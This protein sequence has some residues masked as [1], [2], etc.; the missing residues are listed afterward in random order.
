[1]SWEATGHIRG[2]VIKRAI[3]KNLLESRLR[4]G[5]LRNDLVLQIF[6]LN[7]ERSSDFPPVRHTMV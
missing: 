4:E 5:G 3:T 2:G 7:P 1:M 6:R